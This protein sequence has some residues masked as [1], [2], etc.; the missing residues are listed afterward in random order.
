[1]YPA[2]EVASGFLPYV[3]S[4]FGGIYREVEL[5]LATASSR[6][7]ITNNQHPITNAYPRG[8]LHW[9]WYPDLGHPNPPEETIRR[10]IR[11]AQSLGFNLIKFCLWVPP[12]HYLELMRQEDIQ[13][14][15]ELPIWMPSTVPVHQ[16]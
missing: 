15:M 4:A 11:Q 5:V 6:N 14:W 2:N 1:M 16:E 10:E 7:P 3:H 12:H 8:L 9:G 13:A